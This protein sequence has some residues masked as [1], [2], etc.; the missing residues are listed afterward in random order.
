MGVIIKELIPISVSGGRR[1]ICSK[2]AWTECPLRV[3]LGIG[4]RAELVD[5]WV[6][7]WVVPM[8][9]DMIDRRSQ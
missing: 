6:G 4:W 7:D 9:A 1:V 8:G 2:K 3:L 5:L